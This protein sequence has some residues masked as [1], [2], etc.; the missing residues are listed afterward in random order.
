MRE[1]E[2]VFELGSWTGGGSDA[3]GGVGAGWARIDGSALNGSAEHH[4]GADRR[5]RESKLRS[6]RMTGGE[7]EVHT[8][9][10]HELGKPAVRLGCGL[11]E[12]AVALLGL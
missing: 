4:G 6:S 11:S 8:R 12:I 2:G 1:R 9:T 3:R 10:G 7:I 5:Q